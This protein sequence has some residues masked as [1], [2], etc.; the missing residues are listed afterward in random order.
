[1]RRLRYLNVLMQPVKLDLKTESSSDSGAAVTR[2]EGKLSLE[3]VHYFIETLRPE[4][5]DHLVLDM[6]GVTY[7]DS[8]GVGALVSL[9]VNRKHNGKTFALAALSQY[10][11][12]AMEVAGLFKLIP[13]FGSVEQAVS[14][15][16]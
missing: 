1:M 5:A 2:L 4:P 3:T 11:S 13:T 12:A 6:S 9:F 16:V 14:K 10:A 15:P 7:L 8:A